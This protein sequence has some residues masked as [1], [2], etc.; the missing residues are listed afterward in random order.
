MNRVSRVVLVCACLL[1]GP[2]LAS[3]QSTLAGVVRD[4]S[5]GVLPGATVEAGS[6]SLIEKVRVAITDASGQ[7]RITELQPGVYTVTITLTGF[8]TTRREG[9]ELS[10]S[11][12]TVIDAELKVGNLTETITVTAESPVV[13]VQSTRRQ[14]VLGDAVVRTLP[15]TRGYDSVIAMIPSVS[16]S[17]F[18][19]SENDGHALNPRI[20]LFTSHGGRG[21]EGRVQVDGLNIGNAFNGGGVGFYWTDT[22]NAQEMQVTLTGGLGEAEVGG[23]HMNI[24]PKTGGNSFSGQ[25][26]GS[27][28][29]PWSMA[30][31]LD[32]RLRGFGINEPAEV[33]KNWDVSGA[34]GGPVKRNRLWFFLN[35]R[36][37]GTH[38]ASPGAYGNKNAGDPTKWTYEEDRGIQVR[39]A[40]SGRVQAIRLTSQLSPRNKVGFYF[41]NQLQCTGSTLKPGTSDFCR[42]A[43]ADW[44]AVGG[45]RTVSPEAA[46]GSQDIR[47]YV[48]QGTWSS[49][50]TRR[51]LLEAGASTYM[52]RWGQQ[53]PPDA[54][55]NLIQVADVNTS[56]T[57][58]GLDNFF[59]DWQQATVWRASA[60]YVP[61]AHNM[62]VGYQGAWLAEEIDDQ[63]NDAGLIYQFLNGRPSRLTMRIAPWQISD[64]TSYHAVYAQDQ[65]TTGR[66][67]VQGALRFDYAYSFYPGE[68]NGSPVAS[69]WSP[70][71][72]AFPRTDGVKGYK[73]ITPRMGAAYDLFGNGKTSLKVS[74]GKYLQAATN[75]ANYIFGNP[76]LD[77]R[78]GRASARFQ[79][80]TN[81]SWND[82][83][84]NFVPDCNLMNPAAQPECGA[85][86]NANFGNQFA[87]TTINP[88][89][90]EGWGVRPWDWQ[91]GGSIQHEVLPRT[92]IEAGYYR[93]WFGNFFVTDN[94]AAGPADYTP[95]TVTAP[96]DSRLPDGGG[97]PFTAYDI[98]PGK[99]GQQNLYYTF[100][101]DYGPARTQYWHGV[102]ITVQ[103]R[104]RNGLSFQG[105]T[106]TGR[107]VW[108][109]CATVVKYNSGDPRGCHVDETLLTSFR[110]SVSYLVPKVD[111]QVGA[112]MRSIPGTYTGTTDA[113]YGTNGIALAANYVLTNAVAS[114]SLGRPLSGGLAQVTLNLLTPSQKYGER[115]NQVDLR[116][117]KLLK[118]GRMRTQL[119][120]DLYNLFNLNTTTSYLENYGTDGA[121]YL[122]PLSVLRPRFLRFN[123]TVDF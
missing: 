46:T 97:Y 87:L 101:T 48:M 100:E 41:D 18:G 12:V 108:D 106:S 72:I 51:L 70:R 63:A 96:L 79:V 52:N 85:W 120:V 110:G 109:T 59:L 5:G 61:G 82:L 2:A 22:A 36:D 47:Q 26:F 111:V 32:D 53:K 116:A 107:G 93:R 49:P 54:I 113:F 77:G 29:G 57:Y 64:R 92:S 119:A 83:N 91:V 20:G 99:F 3:A 69:V 103:A 17:G 1:L 80:Q 114:Q 81:R 45:S 31:N 89:V 16:A 58:R 10:G 43:G 115:L 78:N 15:A 11:G 50:V 4:A 37:F 38:Q 75:Q 8:N 14:L 67:T 39:S 88:A 42:E 86:S 60:S 13:D 123:A 25:L 74:A 19:T 6:S 95:Y 118:F 65:W 71:P 76:A 56:K 55:T 102:D 28:A 66:L 24:V 44:T 62:K 30:S 117:G 84:N 104:P 121:T 9:V 90:M 33:I 27:G 98:N 21:N 73:D 7:Y 68:G 105:G 40:T 35:I 34:S 23:I 112:S 122:Q 94:R